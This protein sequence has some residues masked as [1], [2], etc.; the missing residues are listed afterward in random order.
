MYYTLSNMTYKKGDFGLT[1]SSARPS[2]VI[3]P[4]DKLGLILNS[5]SPLE[6]Y[7]LSEM[8]AAPVF[9]REHILSGTTKSAAIEY[10]DSELSY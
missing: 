4:S 6:L 3:T 8:T 5:N 10:G 1:E 2:A 7:V 9:V